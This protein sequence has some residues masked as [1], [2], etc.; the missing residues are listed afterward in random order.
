MTTKGPRKFRVIQCPGL[1]KSLQHRPTSY[2]S[3]FL[4]IIVICVLYL[5]RVNGIRSHAI[6]L[7]SL[8]I[9]NFCLHQWIWHAM[10]YIW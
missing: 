8:G 9:I 7:H 1:Y 10:R 3:Q 2:L 5:A 4:N 6:T